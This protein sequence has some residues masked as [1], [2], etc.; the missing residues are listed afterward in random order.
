MFSKASN[1]LILTI[2]GCFF[3]FA[4]GT[5]DSVQADVSTVNISKAEKVIA[6]LVND[7]RKKKG[8]PK[9]KFVDEICEVARTHSK[10]MGERKVAFGHGEFDDRYKTLKKVLPRIGGAGENVAYGNIS[11]QKIVEDWIKSPHHRD[12]M[13]GPFNLTGVGIYRDKKGILYYT[14][15]F[16]NQTK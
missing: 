14:Q 2:I 9:L 8:L 13:E 4:C 10:R 1:Q 7:Y 16:L 12:N 15:I 3:F 5:A 6:N 11:L